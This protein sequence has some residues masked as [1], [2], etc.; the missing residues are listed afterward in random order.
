MISI[1]IIEDNPNIV[2]DILEYLDIHFKKFEIIVEHT[3]TGEIATRK[4][5]STYYDIVLWDY[6]L[7][8]GKTPYLIKEFDKNSDIILMSVSDEPL[9]K[10]INEN[11]DAYFNSFKT[12]G[13]EYKKELI[14]IP[15]HDITNSKSFFKGHILN[16]IK[17]KNL[18]IL[19][20]V[21]DKYFHS[22]T[23][24]TF[25]KSEIIMITTPNNETLLKSD[26]WKSKDIEFASSPTDIVSVRDYIG[27]SKKLILTKTQ[28]YVTGTVYD[29]IDAVLDGEIEYPF[30]K[31]HE[32]IVV[33]IA[34]IKALLNNTRVELNLDNEI[35]N[36]QLRKRNKSDQY[37]SAD[38]YCKFSRNLLPIEVTHNFKT[39]FEDFL[40]LHKKKSAQ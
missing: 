19:H 34:E 31:I 6:I 7:K 11:W 1:L 24:K 20:V 30:V 16:A 29:S 32:S 35:Y 12:I 4:L 21:L 23:K 37:G 15:K 9:E 38:L 10:F 33:N 5:N 40:R 18:G 17:R 13:I 22:D 8:D 27:R 28:L 26:Q 39:Q 25:N 3:D 14:K 36:I 2:S